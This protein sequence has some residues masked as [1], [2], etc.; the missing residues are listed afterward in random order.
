MRRC[1]LDGVVESCSA[2]MPAVSPHEILFREIDDIRKLE[3]S[4]LNGQDQPEW[5]GDVIVACIVALG[6]SVLLC[7]ACICICGKNIETGKIKPDVDAIMMKLAEKDAARKERKR[8]GE[9]TGLD[10]SRKA[11]HQRGPA[12]APVEVGALGKGKGTTKLKSKLKNQIVEIRKSHQ[13]GAAP[14]QGAT[15]AQIA[16]AALAR[17]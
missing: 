9:D 5:K 3:N 12:K 15:R 8:N 1:S 2:V 14:E 4:E 6:I 13:I 10:D 11:A 16:A 17:V 7:W